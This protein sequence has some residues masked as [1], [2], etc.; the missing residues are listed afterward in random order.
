MTNTAHHNSLQQAPSKSSDGLGGLKV[1]SCTI[2]PLP[3]ALQLGFLLRLVHLIACSQAPAHRLLVQGI[4]YLLNSKVYT[5]TFEY[6]V[7]TVTFDI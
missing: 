7:Y 1:A 6:K 2:R 4:L 3:K 5:V